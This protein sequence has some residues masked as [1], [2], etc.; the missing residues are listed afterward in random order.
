MS[1]A[2]KSVRNPSAHRELDKDATPMEVILRRSNAAVARIRR[3]L[4]VMSNVFIHFSSQDA[5]R[6][7]DRYLPLLDRILKDLDRKLRPSS[8][9]PSATHVHYKDLT[10]Y[11]IFLDESALA[12][13][14]TV[15][16]DKLTDEMK[17]Y[18]Y[19]DSISSA[20]KATANPDAMTKYVAKSALSSIQMSKH[21]VV[22]LENRAENDRQSIL[23]TLRR[24]PEKKFFV[25][26]QSRNFA[27]EILALGNPNHL[28]ARTCNNRGEFAIYRGEESDA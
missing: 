14:H 2:I 22:R 18:I 24:N 25:I 9:A 10:D 7:E 8:I 12:A 23:Q 11:H 21:N 16:L 27:T 3:A 6:L 1:E 5:Q 28:A 19:A 17:V 13:G 4:P 20:A 15:T 26:T